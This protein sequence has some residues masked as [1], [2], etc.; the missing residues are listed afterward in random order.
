M[1]ICRDTTCIAVKMPYNAPKN[2]HDFESNPP[3]NELGF[4]DVFLEKNEFYLKNVKE[5][6][7][8]V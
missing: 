4:V 6:L 2:D 7:L 3:M 8:G 1:I 5:I